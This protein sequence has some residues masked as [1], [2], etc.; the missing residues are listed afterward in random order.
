MKRLSI[1]SSQSGPRT[2]KLSFVPNALVFN[3]SG[4]FVVDSKG[5]QHRGSCIGCQGKN[6]LEY[7]PEELSTPN[8]QAFPHNTSR[9]VC[10]TKAISYDPDIGS[11]FI[12]PDQCIA[13]G[14]C[15][16]RCPTAAIQLNIVARTCIVRRD[17]TIMESCDGT[18]QRSFLDEIASCS[19][20]YS[21]S[22][23]PFLQTF[24]NFLHP[25]FI[26]YFPLLL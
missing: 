25:V 7:R 10:P 8:F 26:L 12:N 17:S 13:C 9:R 18:E 1:N 21:F 14:L 6:C 2:S 24:Y 22:K 16:Q 5:V 4:S 19:R 11:A 23:I 3:N 20:T 15:I